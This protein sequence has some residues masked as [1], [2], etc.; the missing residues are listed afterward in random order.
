M[1]VSRINTQRDLRPILNFA[2][3]GKLGPQKRVGL[4]F[5]QFI[6]QL[7]WDRCCDFQ[8]HF[9]EK[10]SKNIGVFCYVWKKM[11]ITLFFFSKTLPFCRK[12]TKMITTSTLGHPVTWIIVLK[13]FSAGGLPVQTW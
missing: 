3:R 8:K 2:P 12:L 9:A 11:I 6:H 1:E 10:F 5:G 4:H 7:V 13:M